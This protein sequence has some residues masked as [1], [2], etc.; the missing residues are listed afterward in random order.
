MRDNWSDFIVFLENRSHGIFDIAIGF[1]ELNFFLQNI[2]SKIFYILYLF[3]QIHQFE[4]SRSLQISNRFAQPELLQIY[5]LWKSV[6][7]IKRLGCWLWS[8]LHFWQPMRK[9]WAQVLWRHTN[10]H[11]YLWSLQ[12]MLIG[13]A[14]RN[15]LFIELLLIIANKNHF[16]LYMVSKLFY[17]S[18]Q[19]I[20]KMLEIKQVFFTGLRIVFQER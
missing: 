2:G 6:I 5:I 4:W 12:W 9:D 19:T 20:T 18:Y 17:S 3:L 15:W 1:H 14:Y 16:E 11:F 13:W 10:T 7:A 8:F